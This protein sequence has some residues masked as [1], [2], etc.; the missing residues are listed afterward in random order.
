[1]LGYTK[2]TSLSADPGLVALQ[3]LGPQNGLTGKKVACSGA[4]KEAV[5]VKADA[6]TASCTLCTCRVAPGVLEFQRLG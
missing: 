1:M 4:D 2:H 5:A 6:K 3:G